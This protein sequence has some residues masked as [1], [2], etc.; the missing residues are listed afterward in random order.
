[1]TLFVEM[2]FVE[3]DFGDIKELVDC[4]MFSRK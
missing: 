1:M 4:K 3:I 2:A